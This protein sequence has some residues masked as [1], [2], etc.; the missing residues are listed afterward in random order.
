[1]ADWLGLRSESAC[2]YSSD[3]TQSRSSLMPNG[4]TNDLHSNASASSI[5]SVVHLP[6]IMATCLTRHPKP[7]IFLTNSITRQDKPD[8]VLDGVLI[9]QDDRTFMNTHQ[10]LGY[11][12]VHVYPQI[13][14]HA[15][16]YSSSTSLHAMVSFDNIRNYLICGSSAESVGETDLLRHPELTVRTDPL[17]R[18]PPVKLS[19]YEKSF[20]IF[21]N[22]PAFFL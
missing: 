3:D 10:F 13:R 19:R 12:N 4:L 6:D 18:S 11:G 14:P 20:D 15:C 9:I 17:T 5:S 2:Y 21:R 8:E 1:M 22:I 16:Q 7:R